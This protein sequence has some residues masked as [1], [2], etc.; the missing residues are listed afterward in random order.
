MIV[1]EPKSKFRA[2][3]Q[4]PLAMAQDPLIVAAKKAYRAS[5]TFQVDKLYKERSRWLRKQTIARNKLAEVDSQ[6]ERLLVSM[7]KTADGGK[8]ESK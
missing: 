7:A 5:A 1:L 8:E 3:R 4:K 6:I 2:K